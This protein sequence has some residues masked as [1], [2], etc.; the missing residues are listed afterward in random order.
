MWPLT[1]FHSLKRPS[2]S[3][4]VRYLI[5]RQCAVNL[6]LE[7]HYCCSSATVPNKP[8]SYRGKP[9]LCVRIDRQNG[10]SPRAQSVLSFWASSLSAERSL[11]DSKLALV[12][13]REEA[14]HRY[15]P[16]AIVAVRNLLVEISTTY[17]QRTKPGLR[18]GVAPV[19]PPANSGSASA[20]LRPARNARGAR[21]GLNPELVREA[22]R[23]PRRSPRGTGGHCA[24]LR[25]NLPNLAS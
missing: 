24:R 14:A 22:N 9:Q 17:A 1:C 10:R 19:H 7:A 5:T 15:S 21:G 18:V 8:T 2:F 3:L 23:L 20:L 4:G 25:P 12:V 6:L 13:L 16:A 11:L